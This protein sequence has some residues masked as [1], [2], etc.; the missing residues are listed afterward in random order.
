MLEFSLCT[1]PELR[2]VHVCSTPQQT[3]KSSRE[4]AMGDIY[5]I[6]EKKIEER[7]NVT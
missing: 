1:D 3:P 7:G 6:T 4:E 5:D 2:E